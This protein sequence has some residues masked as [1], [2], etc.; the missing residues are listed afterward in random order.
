MGDGAKGDRAPAGYRPRPLLLTE[1]EATAPTAHLDRAAH[2]DR[3]RVG[4]ELWWA[5]Q[6]ELDPPLDAAALCSLL[7]MSAHTLTAVEFGP[8]WPDLASLIRVAGVT[9]RRVMVVDRAW[10]A[11]PL[12]WLA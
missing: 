1:E 10:P 4:A 2:A 5:R 8:A 9:G 3:V 12:P 7:G 11:P 6:H